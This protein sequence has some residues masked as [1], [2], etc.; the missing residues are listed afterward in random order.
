MPQEL[1]VFRRMDLKALRDEEKSYS[2]GEGDWG[3][4]KQGRIK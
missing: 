2:V 3:K 1:G 4:T